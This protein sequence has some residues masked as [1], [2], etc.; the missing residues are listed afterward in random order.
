MSKNTSIILD[1][2]LEQFVNSQIATGNYGSMSDVIRAGLR[3]LEE[4]EMK[5][6]RLRAEVQKGLDSGIATHFDF[7]EFLQAKNKTA[8]QSHA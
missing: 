1:G 7:A 3:L 4:H 6:Q 5:V 2:H 8:G